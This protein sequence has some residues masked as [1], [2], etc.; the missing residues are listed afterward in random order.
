[1][2]LEGHKRF[3][4]KL[5]A[6]PNKAEA[7]SWLDECEGDSFRTVGAWESNEQ[8][9]DLIREI[10]KAGAVEVIAVEIDKYPGGGENTGRLVIV[11][12]CDP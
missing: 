3:I 1:M 4:Q 2:N 8:S 11:M 7:F 10:Y 5:L 6:D 12:P 9:L